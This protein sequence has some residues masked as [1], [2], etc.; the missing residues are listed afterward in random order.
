MPAPWPRPA[1]AERP[2]G[3]SGGGE[4]LSYTR[5][6]PADPTAR[7]GEPGPS[8]ATFRGGVERVDETTG[9]VPAVGP[10]PSVTADQD[11]E[12]RR[13]ADS[14]TATRSGR[15]RARKVRRIVRHIE[16]WSVLKISLL[17]YAALFLI[18][19]VASALLWGAARTAGTVDNAES[20]IT[21]VGGFG[22]CEPV[23]GAEPVTS[24]TVPGAASTAPVD[25]LDPADGTTTVPVDNAPAAS[26]GDEEDCRDGEQLVGEFKFE[27]FRI[28]QAFAL[29]GIVLVLA[30]AAAN[31]VLVLLFNL[32]SDLTGGVHVTVLEEDGPGRDRRSSGSPGAR[33]RD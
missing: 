8:G 4:G 27:D 15:T 7:A 30:G 9:G 25:Q 21:S 3:W 29:G 32:M 18:V 13:A 17:F 19:C 20:F 26:P 2:A 24:T 23:D 10:S 1:A 11:G 16:P 5:R 22:N 6:V 28:F 31:V 14:G 33:R 12:R